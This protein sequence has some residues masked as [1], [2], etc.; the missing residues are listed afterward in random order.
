MSARKLA[1]PGGWQKQNSLSR[2]ASVSHTGAAP[3]AGWSWGLPVPWRRCSSVCPLDASNTQCDTSAGSGRARPPLAEH[4]C[5]SG[6]APPGLAIPCGPSAKDRRC[7]QFKTCS[8]G[9]EPLSQEKTDSVAISDTG[10]VR[11]DADVSCSWKNKRC[12]KTQTRNHL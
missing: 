3:G 12:L 4:L 7:L 5:Q 1:S 8:Q 10:T 9:K 11:E 6:A 2:A